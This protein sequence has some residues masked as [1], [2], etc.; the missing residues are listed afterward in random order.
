MWCLGQQCGGFQASSPEFCARWI[1]H[2][3]YMST[4][5]VASPPEG[6]PWTTVL[7][8]DVPLELHHWIQS[9]YYAGFCR[10][11]LQFGKYLTSVFGA[12]AQLMCVYP[13]SLRCNRQ[14]AHV[15]TSILAT[16]ALPRPLSSPQR[17]GLQW[18][19][20]TRM[21]VGTEKADGGGVGDDRA[22]EASRSIFSTRP[23]G[24]GTVEAWIVIS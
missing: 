19:V 3:N 16:V 23:D 22:W 9:D 5:H 12:I 13:G 18:G 21:A 10:Q 24:E 1:C 15:G 4:Q 20:R 7:Y 6:R 14:S 2:T 11:V 8:R 17:L